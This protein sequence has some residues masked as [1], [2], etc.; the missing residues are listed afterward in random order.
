M[1]T[2][3]SRSEIGGSLPRMRISRPFLLPVCFFL[4]LSHHEVVGDEEVECDLE[5]FNGG[6]CEII[7]ND[8]DGT[9]FPHCHCPL[10]TGGVSCEVLGETELPCELECYNG[11]TCEITEVDGSKHAACQCPTGTSG[12]QCESLDEI[13][14][15]SSPTSAATEPEEVT[16]TEAP[17]PTLPIQ[18]VPCGMGKCYHGSQCVD[19]EGGPRCD[20][21]AIS[22]SQTHYAGKY[23]E[24]EATTYCDMDQVYF[25]INGGECLEQGNGAYSCQCPEEWT[26]PSCEFESQ[27]RDHAFENCTM[28]CLNGGTCRKGPKEVAIDDSGE[29]H[30]DKMEHCVC[31]KGFGG[32]RCQYPYEECGNGEHMCLHGTSCVASLDDKGN[33][34]RWSCECGAQ[35]GPTCQRH[36]TTICTSPDTPKSIHRGMMSLLYCVNDGKCITYQ[37]DGKTFPA[38]KCPPQYT[39]PHCELLKPSLVDLGPPLK[40][41]SNGSSAASLASLLILGVI[42][43]ILVLWFYRRCKGQSTH[44]ITEI[45][46]AA[47]DLE[48]HEPITEEEI[49]GVLEDVELL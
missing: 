34:K 33:N 23:C 11:G 48:D 28:T 3:R 16:T 35:A 38:C 20:C 9:M 17:T 12:D 4:L 1:R 24:F 31:P 29:L 10:G 14:A 2:K 27:T 6:Y 47:D 5:C 42:L 15:T 44:E 25:C 46:H 21:A 7:P 18:N 45:V 41:P 43:V 30:N 19:G 13:S 40:D 36:E 22:D 39:G 8:L 37:Q 32:M 49:D 26:G